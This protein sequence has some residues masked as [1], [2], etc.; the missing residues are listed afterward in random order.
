MKRI[1]WGNLTYVWYSTGHMA[2]LHGTPTKRIELWKPWPR[3][4]TVYVP[5]D[6]PIL[7][8]EAKK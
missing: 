7:E 5:I 1:R 2:V 4:H 8:D 3:D 6:S